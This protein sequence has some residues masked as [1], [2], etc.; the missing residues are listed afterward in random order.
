MQCESCKKRE[1]AVDLTIV[2]GDGKRSLRLCPRCARRESG[3]RPQA[4]AKAVTKINVVLGHLAVESQD[5]ECPEC[6]LTY[7]RF[8]T[9]GRLGCPACYG[10]FGAPMRR[11]LRR[12]HGADSHVGREARPPEAPVADTVADTGGDSDRGDSGRL[13]QLRR[14]LQ[15]AVDEEAYEKAAELRDRIRRCAP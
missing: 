7:E 9:T 11:L 8:R 1:A 13:E 3:S 6:G 12:I 5:A 4:P 14:E 15:Q 10:A 2:S